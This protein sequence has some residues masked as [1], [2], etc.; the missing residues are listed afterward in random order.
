MIN[1]Q[2]VENICRLFL[3][4]GENAAVGLQVLKGQNK[5][6]KAAVQEKMQPLLDGFNK[7]T[8]RGI[9]GIWKAI[10]KDKL[11][12]SERGALWGIPAFSE[13]VEKI[14]YYGISWTA[15]PSTIGQLKDLKLL[16]IMESKISELPD[17]IGEL[18][19]LE[20]LD[21]SFN[22][23]QTI[24]TTIGK[25]KDLKIL[26]FSGNGQSLKKLPK[27]IGEMEGLEEL[28]L[29]QNGL[30]KIPPTFGDLGK[31]KVLDVHSNKLTTLPDEIGNLSQLEVLQ[32]GGNPLKKLPS[33]IQKLQN[34]KELVIES[35]SSTMTDFSFLAGLTQLEKLRMNQIV[36]EVSQL[37]QLKELELRDDTIKDIPI[38]IKGLQQLEV[39]KINSSGLEDLS[40]EIIAGL[41]NLKQIEGG[42]MAPISSSRL[43]ELEKQFPTITF[44]I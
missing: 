7:K 33:S 27:E 6:T 1:E 11:T 9:N 22:P 8:I 34:L 5:E 39:L 28:L 16:R 44:D 31:L 19:S 29:A 18:T 20:K 12:Q 40:E 23:L 26:R 25:L 37:V 42:F 24:P 4:D 14:D 21:F 15:L 36:P 35:N 2:E 32:V 41:P 10:A 38:E 43:A 13:G 3:T 17:E 30:T